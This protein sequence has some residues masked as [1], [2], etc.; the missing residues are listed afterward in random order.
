MSLG[1]FVLQGRPL[2]ADVVCHAVAPNGARTGPVPSS[3]G[4]LDVAWASVIRL[5]TEPNCS[6]NATLREVFIDGEKL[7]L[8]SLGTSLQLPLTL[9]SGRGQV[10]DRA[11]LVR[12][13]IEV[14]KGTD[15]LFEE[16]SVRL[17]ER[18]WWMITDTVAYAITRDSGNTAI[19]GAGVFIDPCKIVSVRRWRLCGQQDLIRWSFVVH[20]LPPAQESDPA[21]IGLSPIG[22]G[23]FDNRIVLGVGWNASRRGLRPVDHNR[24]VYVGFSASQ[25]LNPRP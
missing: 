15:T 13:R 7:A 9:P 5:E 14:R 10:L 1:L 6:C 18:S 19:A 20:L 3:S 4:Y 8:S 12:F 25:V 2:Y 17:S 21:D 23:L 24:Y 22:A 16:F 11:G